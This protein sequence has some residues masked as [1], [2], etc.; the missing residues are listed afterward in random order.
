[1]KRQF[2][3]IA[4]LLV[5]LSSG[6]LAAA[7]PQASPA[8]Q[9][10]AI[11]DIGGVQGG[12][13]V[14]VGC[15]DGKLTAALY[16]NDRYLVHGLDTSAD[17]IQKARQHIKSLG[18]Y[19]TVSVEQFDGKALP[20][21]DNIVN[22]LVAESPLDIPKDE[23]LRVLVPNGVAC[24]KK[25]GAWTRTVK[26]RPD[27]IDEW[28]HYMHDP[29]NN[30]VAHDTAIGPLRHLQWEAA[31]R[32][33]RHHEFT[34]S[35]SAVVSA[36]GRIFSIMDMGSRAS[37]QMP[38]KL[39]LTARDAFNGITLW[40]RPIESWFNHLWP[41]KDGPAQPP[42]RLVAVGDSV[43]VTLGLEAPVSRLDAATGKILKT[44][45]G[46]EFTE[47]ILLSEGTLFLLKNSKSMNPADY[48]PK[49]MV[50]WDEKNRTRKDSEGWLLKPGKR[51]V[52]A[53]DAD[54]DGTLWKTDYPIEPLTLTVDEGSVYF[55][56]WNEVVCLDRK[57]G[58]EKWR[59]EPVAQ[60]KTMGYVYGPTMVAYG[61]VLLFADG[62]LKRRMAAF[63]K[64]DGKKLWEAPHYAG[65]HSGSPE[66]LFVIDGLVWCAK[67][68][69]GGR[70]MGLCTGRDPKTG[71]VKREFSADINTYWFHHR[72]YR[73]KATDEYILTSRTGIE[74][75]DIRKKRWEAHHWVRGACSYGILPCNGLIDAPPS[76]CACYLDTKVHGFSA[77]APAS[78]RTFGRPA[79][80]ASRLFKGP[81]YDHN[82]LKSKISNLKS[83]DWPTYRHDAGRSGATTT[84]V[85]TPLSEKWQVGLGGELTSPV[86]A[87]GRVYIASK[88]T[89][90]LY[91]LSAD[92]GEKT[93]TFTAGAEVDSPPTVYRGRVIFGSADGYVYC[94]R[95]SDGAL[96]W[97]FRAAPH[98]AKL[99]SYGQLQSVWP[100][101][102]SVLIHKGVV[103]CVAGRSTFLDGGLRFYRLDALTG[104]VL[105]E[106]V[107]NDQA[108]PQKDVKVLNMP[109][110]L[111]DILS[112][113]GNAVYMREQAFDLEGNRIQ[114]IDPTTEPFERAT[115][116]LG[117]N[118]HLFSPTGFLD[119]D[120][121]HRSYWLYGRAFSSGCNW[122]YRAGRYAPA[123]RM[124]VFD[125]D[126]VYGFGRQPGLFVWSPVLE[127]HLFCADKQAAPDAI[128]RVKA[129][130]KKSG[131]SAVFNR[132]FTRQAA[133]Q[134]R[135][136][137]KLHWSVEEPPLHARAMVLAGETFFVAGPSDV[138]NEDDAFNR[139]ND[140]KVKAEI[141]AQEAAY[142]GKT[143][144]V[145]MAVSTAKGETLFRLDLPA[146][147]VWDGMAAAN[148][149]LY[150]AMSNG[151]LVCMGPDK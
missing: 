83:E 91:A 104:R 106:G 71:Q 16:A 95:G 87:G 23:I 131:R 138:L 125:D 126:R 10:Q 145:L 102:G 1:M 107:L 62:R 67:V 141:L 105:S 139:P 14:H 41:L 79:P 27:N 24:I 34:T 135:L 31:P 44:Y 81:A 35:V 64:T 85:N 3:A 65:G 48:Y 30:A 120:A 50:C 19:E 146:P 151:T 88:D 29:T 111:P 113:D 6:L 38:S 63:S 110:A 148:G 119:D 142:E 143:P 52:M 149:K 28:T 59:S 127:N 9:A 43:Y 32:Y 2:C 13:I 137:P 55:H 99:V 124:L 100:V 132:Q 57:T 129:W 97:R 60:R 11:L 123:G 116:Q 77:L 20:Y 94:L 12:L 61:D 15:G 98:D 101:H 66:D 22:L 51:A 90:T 130:S 73:A 103:Y 80:A 115:L 37:I 68:A 140:P 114:T 117:P 112:C 21:N 108:N 5:I 25:R 86:I 118:A 136:A 33:A 134:D 78:Q 75:I 147:P 89:H 76:P 70:G 47:E 109:V 72:C 7:A 8:Q 84:K 96:I 121:W 54:S 49:L 93:W 39:M 17:N 150:M 26:P 69:G 92:R 36:N 133:A 45:A 74:F 42:R 53:L 40:R 18:L 56:D 4:T 122:W 46:T 82:N 144:A 128:Q 58:K